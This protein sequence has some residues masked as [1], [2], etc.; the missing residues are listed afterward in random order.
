MG[1]AVP[2]ESAKEA[3]NVRWAGCNRR[4]KEQAEGRGSK[5]TT[6]FGKGSRSFSCSSI[7][8]RLRRSGLFRV[9]VQTSVS[10]FS[11]SICLI[12]YNIFFTDVKTYISTLEVQKTL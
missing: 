6:A 3:Q 8:H 2:T 7:T 1:R 5:S 11:R 10:T 4:Q 9:L 12:S